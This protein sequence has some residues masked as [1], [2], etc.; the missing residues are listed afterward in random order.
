MASKKTAEEKIA[1]LQAKRQQLLE[2]EKKI[3]AQLAADQR[4]ARTKRLIEVGATVEKVLGRPI[5][6][7]D[8]PKLAAFLEGQEI[9]GN[10]FSRAMNEGREEEVQYGENQ[11]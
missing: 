8:L 10:Y 6:K 7:D 4:K 2:Q 3:K 11:N 9:R 5:E 1:E